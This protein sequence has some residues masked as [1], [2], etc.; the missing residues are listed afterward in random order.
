ML[1]LTARENK[2]GEKYHLAR[3]DFSVGE[4]WTKSFIHLGDV[5]K[6]ILT[7]NPSE[8]I[9]DV[10]FREKD[11]ISTPIQQYLKCL[12]SVYETPTDSELFLTHVCNIQSLNS[13]GQAVHEGRLEAVSLLLNYI[14]HIQQHGLSTIYKISY[15][16]QLGMVVMDDITIKNLELF[17]SSYEASEKYSLIGILDRTKTTS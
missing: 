1:A 8:I 3:G 13:F 14:K 16:A 9:L 7:L 6:W 5:Q 15:H 4:Y 2:H 10:D 11:S 12:I 17:S